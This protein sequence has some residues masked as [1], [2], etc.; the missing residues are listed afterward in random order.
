MPK[1]SDNTPQE[2]SL[3]EKL[4]GLGPSSVHKSYFSELQNKLRDLEFS[5]IKYRTIVESSPV[6]MLFYRLESENQFILTGGNSSAVR[7]LKL[8][9]SSLIEKTLEDLF[10]GIEKT[11]I[12]SIFRKV[13]R[14][15]ISWHAKDF[16]Y[17]HPDHSAH[18]E[19]YAFQP[20]PKAV[21]VFFTDISEQIQV[22]EERQRL[23]QAVE[24]TTDSI[25]ILDKEGI[26]LYTNS[27]FCQMTGYSHQ[28]C[29]G[30]DFNQLHLASQNQET[31]QEIMQAFRSGN[32][33]QGQVFN[34]RK[35]QSAYIENITLTPVRNPQGKILQ[36]IAV[37]RDITLQVKME[38]TLQQQ[39]K[40]ESMGRLAG[41]IA[42]DFNNLLTPILG[43]LELLMDDSSL[44]QTAR[45]N[46]MTVRKAAE[47]AQSLT[48]ELLTFSRK[49]K[50][51]LKPVDLKVLLV[52]F[53][54]ML[55]RT[56]RENIQISLKTGDTPLLIQGDDTQIKRVI[57][58]LALN[59]QDAMPQGGTLSIETRP[60]EL[61]HQWCETTPGSKPG[62]YI[63][64]SIAD[65]GNGMSKEILEHLYEPF[66]STKGDSGTGLGLSTVYGIIQQHQGYIQVQSEPAQGTIF[67]LYFP[68]SQAKSS[69]PVKTTP[70]KQI[71][72]GTETILVVEDNEMVRKLACSI[73]KNH[74]FKTLEA[75]DGIECLD[76]YG[77][78]SKKID[79]LL[80]DVV[81]PHMNGR[82][83]YEKMLELRPDIKVL[84]M[85]GYPEDI[86]TPQGVVP[87]GLQ[88][89]QKPF[90]F[91]TLLEKAREVLDQP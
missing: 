25:I 71:I 83:L 24:Q 77:K 72:K 17:Q 63:L 34:K 81:M 11:D 73:L 82:E 69:S 26:I 90:T 23:W 51:E 21:A 29:R 1:P 74:G 65:T 79:L 28:E 78:S 70:I 52:D 46:L 14:D 12:P 18:Y 55:E 19:I 36:Y 44:S 3:R 27:A 88:F 41:G 5:E 33:W 66:Y 68:Q 16:Y 49:Q 60:V 89:L 40:L 22:E 42:H 54:E 30:K 59:A 75:K 35:D 20:E 45:E 6:G 84:Y 58:N 31:C 57:L 8:K 48:R 39:Q 10:P 91:N 85:S 80:T 4:L 62:Q 2:N 38:E 86:I 76:L 50:V 87:K 67:Q 56:I 13:A 47:G 37:S 43:Y 64:L 61:D 15:G 7:I 32:I 53:K 9:I